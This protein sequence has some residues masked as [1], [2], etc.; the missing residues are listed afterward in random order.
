MPIKLAKTPS[1][2]VKDLREGRSYIYYEKSV[3][4]NLGNYESARV[5]VGVSLPIQPTADE[6]ALIESTFEIGDE[7][8][9]KELEIQLK[10]L[11]A[12]K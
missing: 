12:D 11:V 5:T 6:V 9:T 4:K 8:V 7:L 1:E 2:I 10:E 3:T